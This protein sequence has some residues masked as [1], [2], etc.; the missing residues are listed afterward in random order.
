MKQERSCR[1]ANEVG[2]ARAVA[3][4][5]VAERARRAPHL[6]FC[7]LRRSVF[8]FWLLNFECGAAFPPLFRLLKTNEGGEGKIEGA[9]FSSQL[10]F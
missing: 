8:H 7:Q 9:A 4:E 1:A 3:E 5:R 10:S 2:R 6:L